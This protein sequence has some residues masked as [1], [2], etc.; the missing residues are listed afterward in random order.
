[1]LT[2]ETAR[3]SRLQCRKSLTTEERHLKSMAIQKIVFSLPGYKDSSTVMVY[4]DF[5]EEVETTAIA[6]NILETGKRLIIP[7]CQGQEI[8][9]CQIVDLT[10]DIQKGKFGIREPRAGRLNPVDPREIDLVLV[11]GVAFDSQGNRVGFGRGYYD[12]FL[13]QLR[14][15]TLLVGLAFSCQMAEKI[16]VEEHDVR[17]SLIVTEDGIIYPAVN[18]GGKS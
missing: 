16:E 4:L 11:P 15:D 7:F 13:P 10:R 12:R 3:S 1:M 8:L 14:A 2:K 18:P 9:P 5:Q 6:E 17:M